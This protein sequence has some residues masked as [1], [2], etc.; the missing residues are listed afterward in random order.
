M[1]NLT[2]NRVDTV[3]TDADEAAI[4]TAV[5]TINSKLPAGSLD[6]EQRSNFKSMDVEN[7]I[8]VQDAITEFTISGDG[9]L[10]GFLKKE[11]IEHDLKLYEQLDVVEAKLQNSMRKVSDL[12]RICGHEAYSAALTVYKI[13]EAANFAGIPG[14]KQAYDKLKTRFDA[15][16]N[17]TGRN[18]APDLD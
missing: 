5:D 9:I 16:G 6:E 1:S 2:E 4:N 8:F 15:Q 14:A 10:P 3:L 7:K 18:A 11:F 17:G 12:K 13:F